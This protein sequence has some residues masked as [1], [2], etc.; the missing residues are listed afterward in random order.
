MIEKS[1]A[2]VCAAHV[3]PRKRH[4]PA[5]KQKER[6]CLN[7]QPKKQRK[8]EMARCIGRTLITFDHIAPRS[9]PLISKSASLKNEFC[10]LLEAAAFNKSFQSLSAGT[11]KIKEPSA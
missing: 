6:T 11:N 7:V 2:V 10:L 9:A 8:E 5:T 4:A 1:G 3:N